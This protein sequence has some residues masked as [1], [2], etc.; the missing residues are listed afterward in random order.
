M[1][2]RAVVGNF[3][4]FLTKKNFFITAGIESFPSYDIKINI[5]ISRYQNNNLFSINNDLL[6]GLKPDGR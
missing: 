3:F 4:F 6:L 5:I 2:G 1:A